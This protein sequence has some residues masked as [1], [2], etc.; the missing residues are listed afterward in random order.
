MTETIYFQSSNIEPYPL[1]V[2][3]ESRY[4]DNIKSLFSEYELTDGEGVNKD[5]VFAY[6]ILED[7]NIYD[8]QAVRID[9]EDKTVGYLSRQAAPI[10]RQSIMQLG[11]PKITGACYASIRGGFEKKGGETADFG[12]RLDLDLSKPLQKIIPNIAPPSEQKSSSNILR[13]GRSFLRWFFAPRHRWW[14]FIIAIFILLVLC[15]ALQ[16]LISHL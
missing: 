1:E 7:E 5:D 15:G 11:L 13:Y 3:G 14:K 8:H 12:V 2:V 4:K 16:D 10:Y 9:I 6:L